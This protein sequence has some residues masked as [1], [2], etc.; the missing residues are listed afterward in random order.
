MTLPTSQKLEIRFGPVAFTDVTSWLE[1]R[2]PVEAHYGRMSAT[3][4]VESAVLTATLDNRDGRFTAGNPAGAYWPNVIQGKEIR[5]TV[6]GGD[7]VARVEFEGWI[8][9]FDP[10]FDDGGVSGAIVTVTAADRFA[11]VTR[12]LL[13]NAVEAQRVEAGAV[14]CD[15]WA[16]TDRGSA[17]QLRNDGVNTSLRPGLVVDPAR[18]SGAATVEGGTLTLGVPDGGL[19]CSGM[20]S[21]Q[22]TD[23]VGPVVLLEVTRSTFSARNESV[24]FWHRTTEVPATYTILSRGYSAYDLLWELRLV[25]NGSQTDLELWS[26]SGAFDG[27]VAFGVNDGMW[28]HI[29]LKDDVASNDTW[30]AGLDQQLNT[31]TSLGLFNESFRLTDWV[32]VGGGMAPNGRGRQHHCTTSDVAQVMVSKNTSF[33]YAASST[34]LQPRD[35]SDRVADYGGLLGAVITVTGVTDRA[36]ALPDVPGSTLSQVMQEIARTV[37]GVSWVKPDGTEEFRQPDQCRPGTPVLTIDVEADAEGALTLA[38]SVDSA[39]TRVTATSPAGDVTVI[40]PAESGI[41]VEDHAD[42]CAATISQARAAA[43]LRLADSRS[44]AVRIPQITINLATSTTDLWDEAYAL[45]PTA[46]V[47][48]TGL[49]SAVIGWTHADF[50]VA[51]W[52]K[53]TVASG[54]GVSDGFWLDLDLAPA[55][56]VAETGTARAAAGDGAMTAT[57][58]TITGTG[59]GT[60]VVTTVSGPTLST[61]AS[62]YP[63]DFDWW[64]ERVTVAAPPAGAV[65]PQTITVTARGVAPSVARTHGAAEAFDVWDPGSAGI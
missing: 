54:D 31:Y 2:Y 61:D 57:A 65:S 45:Y 4:D 23:G 48:L 5:W 30:V 22:P 3:G 33:G 18:T 34:P 64:G 16:F 36:I 8:Q 10:A 29:W 13:D 52:T 62:D 60:L 19:A 21:F 44:G 41:V 14:G 6:T 56:T 28:R 40:S 42:T 55:W 59:T 37:G 25:K 11:T 9:S 43:A 50:F 1:Q 27:T 53:R 20:V 17:T 26:P 32:T 58:G 24:Q 7:G 38:S 46:R 12:T 15:V 63:C 49:P 35:T 51:G 39:P 47:R